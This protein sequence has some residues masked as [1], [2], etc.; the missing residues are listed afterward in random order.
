MYGNLWIFVRNDK[1][2]WIKNIKSR[3]DWFY[4]DEI[5]YKRLNHELGI[6]KL[7]HQEASA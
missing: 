4:K 3:Q 2:T 5:T 7:E 6:A 1:I